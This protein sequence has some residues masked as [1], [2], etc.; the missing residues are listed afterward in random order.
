MGLIDEISIKRIHIEEKIR[1]HFLSICLLVLIIFETINVLMTFVVSIP[2][3]FLAGKLFF[4]GREATTGNVSPVRKL[5][6]RLLE[7]DP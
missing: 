5:C 7:C 1:G 4:E 2:F 3:W 6:F